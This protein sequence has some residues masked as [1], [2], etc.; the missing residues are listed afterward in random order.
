LARPSLGASA[1]R[2]FGAEGFSL[3]LISRHQNRVDALA[4]DLVAAGMT[5]RGYAASVRD[6]DA[7]T[8]APATGG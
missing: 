6:P 1:L 4:A 5:A 8:G 7:L 2:R 3:A